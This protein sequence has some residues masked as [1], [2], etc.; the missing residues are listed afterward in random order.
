[1][2]AFQP[3][4]RRF[5]A[6]DAR[7]SESRV[8]RSGLE[9][10]VRIRDGKAEPTEHVGVHG[11]ACRRRRR[12]INSRWYSRRRA[13]DSARSTS[14]SGGLP[15]RFFASADMGGGDGIGCPQ[16]GQVVFGF[17]RPP[18]FYPAGV[19]LERG[20]HEIVAQIHHRPMVLVAGAKQ[21]P[22][23]GPPVPAVVDQGHGEIDFCLQNAP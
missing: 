4:A 14:V 3:F 12:R 1:M 22:F 23:V 18:V 19:R 5:A 15:R 10:P 17:I 20:H 2:R 11:D 13:S 8:P 16:C 9:F 7:S 21:R 6:H